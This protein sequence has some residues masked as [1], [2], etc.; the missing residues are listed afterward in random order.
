[1]KQIWELLSGNVPG[2]MFLLI[3][4]LAIFNFVVY[5]FHSKTGFRTSKFYNKVRYSGSIV[6]ICIYG[7]IRILSTAPQQPSRLAFFP[8]IINNQPKANKWISIAVP[9]FAN[10]HL[11]D[12][13]TSNALIYPLEWLFESVSLDSV[14]TV[15]T[16][17]DFSKKIN[18]DYIVYGVAEIDGDNIK[19]KTTFRELLK[20]EQIDRLQIN[21]QVTFVLK[22]LYTESQ[23]IVI[24][25][26]KFTDI[27]FQIRD[28]HTDRLPA[29]NVLIS[30]YQGMELFFEKDYNKTLQILRKMS[31]DE[32]NNIKT[33][34]MFGMALSE[35]TFRKREKDK[36]E[37][38]ENGKGP[39][40]DV[41][42]MIEENANREF[43]IAE[44]YLDR[45]INLDTL[46]DRSHAAMG[47]HFIQREKWWPAQKKL[48]RAIQLNPQNVFAKL[49]ASWLHHSR[50]EEMGFKDEGEILEDALELNSASIEIRIKLSNFIS[51]YNATYSEEGERALNLLKEAIEINPYHEDALMSLS[52]LYQV[53]GD[54]VN[55]LDI[56]SRILMINPKNSNAYYNMGILLFAEGDIDESE[57]LFRRSIILSNHLDAHLY[58]AYILE[59][60]GDLGEAFWH[61][62]HRILNRQGNDDEYYKEAARQLRRYSPVEIDAEVNRFLKESPYLKIQ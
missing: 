47:W 30:Y 31:Q 27:D 22:D 2:G 33:L 51:L 49:Y 44:T 13:K 24:D 6:L 14:G 28:I 4:P 25:F 61:Y 32:I 11:R 8:L 42:V 10:E 20:D 7:T 54:P 40:D 17:L 21:N 23:K 3:I 55:A 5:Y 1:M 41:I 15:E 26:L 9:D 19:M 59:K 16:I 48:L 45:A 43:E 38:K 52:L 57:E 29:T 56:Y 36:K 35:Q 34:R 12:F 62:R 60:K 37:S 39:R 58:L 46:D 53:R 50:H 18:L